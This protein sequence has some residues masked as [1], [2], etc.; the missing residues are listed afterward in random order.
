MKIIRMIFLFAEQS[1]E[2]KKENPHIKYGQILVKFGIALLSGGFVLIININIPQ[3]QLSLNVDARIA[4]FIII[5]GAILILTGIVLI[6]SGLSSVKNEWLIKRFYYLK[7]LE[8][9]TSDP[10]FDALP[11]MAFWYHKTPILLTIKNQKLDIIFED[12]LHAKR[13]IEEKVEQYHSKEIFFAGLAR[14]PCLFFIGHSFRNAHSRITLIDH[15]HQTDKWF[16]LSQIDDPS[17]NISVDYS[18]SIGVTPLSDIAVTIEFTSEIMRME[19]PELLQNN[20]VRIKPSVK[21][22]H[23]LIES[24]TAL[25]RIVEDIINEIIKLNKICNRVH[26]FIAAQSTVVFSL[27]RRYLDGQIG[28][29]TIY[30]YDPIIKSYNWAISLTNNILGMEKIEL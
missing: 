28:N 26:L 4:L 11:K 2:A 23:N 20:I 15:N 9:Q 14:V 24:D 13:N 8:N 27:G 7:G 1:R 10:P 17:L 22:S 3:I 19:L 21:H 6:I 29:I 12:L 30:N 16:K 5:I 18:T 25:Q